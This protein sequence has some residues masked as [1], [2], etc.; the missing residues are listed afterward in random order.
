M[1][2]T[3]SRAT[4]HCASLC[5]TLVI[6]ILSTNIHTAFKQPGQ[7]LS[8]FFLFHFSSSFKS[9][10]IQPP[11]IL[12]NAKPFTKTLIISIIPSKRNPAKPRA[13]ETSSRALFPPRWKKRKERKTKGAHILPLNPVKHQRGDFFAQRKVVR[14]TTGL[15]I[16]CASRP[17]LCAS[18]PRFTREKRSNDRLPSSDPN[19]SAVQRTVTP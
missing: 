3:L 8:T 17:R 16:C 2:P 19:F 6:N 15:F 12:N 13:L 14:S 11:C 10:F 1:L 4:V 7:R 9:S 18:S 5:E